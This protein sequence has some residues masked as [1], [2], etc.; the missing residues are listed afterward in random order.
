[1]E[2]Y[3]EFN[4]DYISQHT[5]T[6]KSILGAYEQKP[7]RGLE[8]GCMEGRAT[9]WFVKNILTHQNSR[10][11]VIDDFSN[12]RSSEARFRLCTES[13]RSKVD[14]AKGTSKEILATEKETE[15]DFI[16]VDG[17]HSPLGVLTDACL[18]WKLLK[19]GGIMIFDDY[20]LNNSCD[21]PKAGIDAFLSIVP[22]EILHKDYQVIIKKGA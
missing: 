13:I 5:E 1:M 4:Y 7:A 2:D 20:E 18:A 12:S 14:L 9:Y 3:S 8:I 16:Y 15:Y 19:D 10:I 11:K 22:H 21:H 17:D 6:W